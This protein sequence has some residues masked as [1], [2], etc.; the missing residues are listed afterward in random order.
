ML[1]YLIIIL[2]D[3]S[4]S[5]C[6]YTG[7]SK[8]PGL[9]PY[10]SLRKA[11]TFALKNNL[12]VN[13]L[14]PSFPLD[15]KYKTL[16]E[17]VEHIKIVPYKLRVKYPDSIT[18]V[19]SED[20]EAFSRAKNIS[21]E[22]VILWLQKEELGN[23][24]VYTQK[25]FARS[26][27]IN[28]VINGIEDIEDS[29]LNKYREQ[30]QKI[31]DIIL[32]TKEGKSFPEMNFLTDR[33]SLSEMNNCEAGITHL[34]AAPNG[35]LYICPAFYFSNPENTLGE[36]KNEIEMKNRHLLEIK[37][38]PVCR[39]CD[40]Y[41]C[42]RCVFLNSKL[43]TELNTPSWQQCRISHAER[44]ASRLLIGKLK[45]TRTDLCAIPQIPELPYDDPFHFAA[46]NKITISEFKTYKHG[47]Q[48]N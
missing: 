30:L 6:T 3:T 11:V 35:K 41:Q 28:L 29:D 37:Y 42:K 9:I 38:A 18:V 45:E 43:T 47:K 12:K 17:D 13:F 10:D 24:S 21:G 48:K 7:K 34:T 26:H 46:K 31:S 40:A 5:F 4:V 14:Y 1:K 8:E 33:I 16:I 27:R 36:I 20:I 22:N 32:R 23:L 19:K 44:E 15:K 39:I 2:A 25:L